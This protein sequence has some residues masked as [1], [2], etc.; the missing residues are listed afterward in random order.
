MIGVKMKGKEVKEMIK[1]LLNKPDMDD[2]DDAYYN[3]DLPHG[4]TRIWEPDMIGKYIANGS[5]DGVGLSDSST[6]IEKLE[7][8]V[9]LVSEKLNVDRS[10]IKLYTGERNC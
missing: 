6:S 9:K 8:Y 2:D 3:G 10:K 1:K 5:S 7:E 4:L